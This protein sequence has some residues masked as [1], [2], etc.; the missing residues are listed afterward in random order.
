MRLIVDA[1]V[2]VKWFAADESHVEASSRLR[3]VGRDLLAPDFFL[4]EVANVLWKKTRRGEFTPAEASAVL[5]L[6][7]G[8]PVQLVASAPLVAAAL[9]LATELDHPVYDCIYLALAV[10]E[11]DALV[12]ADRRLFDKISASRLSP[13]V[14][15]VAAPG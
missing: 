7:E 3:D 11:G 13:H 14:R 15:W 10:R 9:E 2:A 5:V 1:N 8:G 6:L 4:V 12:T